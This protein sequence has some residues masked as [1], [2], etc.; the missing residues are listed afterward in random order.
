MLTACSTSLAAA[1]STAGSAFDLA[2]RARIDI[3]L[4]QICRHVGGGLCF[5]LTQP[6]MLL[7]LA[8]S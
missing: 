1:V 7:A 2:D 6:A 4:Q 5:S 3:Q 8:P